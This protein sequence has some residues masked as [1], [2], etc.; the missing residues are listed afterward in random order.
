MEKVQNRF[1]ADEHIL[2]LETM[3]AEINFPQLRVPPNINTILNQSS[4]FALLKTLSPED[5]SEYAVLLASYSLYLSIEENRYKSYIDWC[6]NNIRTIIGQ[7]MM[8]IPPEIG[9]YFNNID[10]YIRGNHSLAKELDVKKSLAQLKYTTIHKL[11]DRMNILIK[12]L[13]SLSYT[14]GKK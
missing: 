9:T 7:E 8:N 12:A 2:M 10:Y 13:E 6:E 3:K 11:N 4:D 5:L 14:K 1:S